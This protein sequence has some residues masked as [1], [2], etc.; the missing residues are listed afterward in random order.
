MNVA[1]PLPAGVLVFH[2]RLIPPFMFDIDPDLK[3]SPWLRDYPGIGNFDGWPLLLKLPHGVVLKLLQAERHL[4]ALHVAIRSFIETEPY[5]LR[6]DLELAGSEHVYRLSRVTD[7][8]DSIGLVAGDAVHCIRS[9]LDHLAYAEAEKGVAALGRGM[10][11]KEIRS[12]EFPVADTPERYA[13]QVGRLGMKLLRTQF[14]AL[15]R[16]LQPFHQPAGWG[17]DTSPL[18]NISEL[19][20]TDKHRTVNTTG[21]ANPM[22]S[23]RNPNL[24]PYVPV[25]P[26][27]RPRKWQL[28]TEV[29]RWRFE[30]PHPEVEM[31]VHPEFSV[32]FEDSPEFP[33]VGADAAI[34]KW[35]GQIVETVFFPATRLP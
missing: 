30:E 33:I 4:R 1:D 7:A 8:P 26:R 27:S 3:G 25:V 2:D 6:R 34:A 17:A 20:N 11:D 9:A 32:A 23:I 24:P 21:F 28:G 14:L 18:W 29:W 13:S 22:V 12:V 19:D 10:N 31:E 35:L 5:A 16:P 15:I